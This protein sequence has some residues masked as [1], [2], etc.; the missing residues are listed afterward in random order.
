[1]R[2]RKAQVYEFGPY[3]LNL[4]ECRLWRGNEEI[5]LRPKLFDLLEL[6]IEY[7]GQVIEKS[8]LLEHLWPDSIVEEN[9]LTVSVNALRAALN[10]GRYIETVSKRG[11]RFT[12]EVEVILGQPDLPPFT[13]DSGHLLES[14]GGALPL[15]SRFYISRPADAEFCNAIAGHDSIVLVKGA[16]QMGKTSLLARGLEEARK[17]GAV[18]LLIDFQQLSSAA[19]ES[20]DK[21]LLTVAS[22]IAHQMDLPSK[23]NQ[24]WDS[25]LGASSNF[26]RFMRRG[27][28]EGNRSY[29][30]WALDEVDRLFNYD[31]AGEIFG[32]FRSWHNLR[33]LDPHGP[34]NRL[35]LAI[36]YATEAHLF[37]TDLNQSPFNVGTRLTLEDFTFEQL[38]DLN[39]R[40]GG[41]L[42]QEDQVSRFHKLVGG[43][44][45]LSQR[46]LY[47]MARCTTDL[48]TI[49]QQA[50]RDEGVFGDHLKRMRV[51]L[52]QD[53]TL[54]QELRGLLQSNASLSQTAFYRLRSAGILSGDSPLEPSLRCGLY[55]RYLK[56]HLA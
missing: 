29:L 1:M 35:T 54:L 31:Y 22:L 45:Y 21:L 48:E 25:F 12:A 18:V 5:K 32:L 24:G 44:P 23:P 26:E 20:A 43:H 14:P 13:A 7:R 51:S 19:F 15:H 28:L 34:W 52:E 50:C 8:E 36:A 53:D 46:G 37:I 39:Q 49:E 38:V 33:A 56:E 55:A 16:R 40:Y 41:P 10:A 4:N 17:Q 3:R 2:I 27:V 9:N 11:Y 30:V 6:L 47:E 42:T